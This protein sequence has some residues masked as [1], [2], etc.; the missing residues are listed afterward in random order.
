MTGNSRITDIG[1]NVYKKHQN[2]KLLASKV[3][4]FEIKTVL[5]AF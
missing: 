3:Y 2:I 5:V 1:R 4:I